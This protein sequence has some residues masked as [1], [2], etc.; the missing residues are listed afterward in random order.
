MG[1]L[2]WP[3]LVLC[4][5]V[6]YLTSIANFFS[7]CQLSSVVAIC[8]I[9]QVL[10]QWVPRTNF[11][12]VSVGYIHCYLIQFNETQLQVCTQAMH[13]N[14]ANRSSF[15]QFVQQ[16]PLGKAQDSALHFNWPRSWFLLV[17]SSPF[18]L[19]YPLL[20]PLVREGEL[21]PALLSEE[22]VKSQAVNDIKLCY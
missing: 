5:I 13:I 8:V 12:T 2:K 3:V 1:L 15:H 6:F 11:M 20:C 18:C 21:L 14:S 4:N 10:T 22:V 19:L 9:Y 16:W 7:L 17:L